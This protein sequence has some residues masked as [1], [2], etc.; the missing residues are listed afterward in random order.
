MNNW[1]ACNNKYPCAEVVWTSCGYGTHYFLF[2]HICRCIFVF[3]SDWFW[4]ELLI[5]CYSAIIMYCMLEYLLGVNFLFLIYFCLLMCKIIDL[6]SIF[7]CWQSLPAIEPRVLPLLEV[8][9]QV[10]TF[11]CQLWNRGRQVSD[12]HNQ[13]MKCQYW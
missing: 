8:A 9:E 6:D 4:L 2:Q 7:L 12:R 3:H 1:F 10:M 13:T 11:G 5:F